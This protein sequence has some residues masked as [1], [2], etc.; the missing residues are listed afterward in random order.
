MLFRSIFKFFSGKLLI[1]ILKNPT[2]GAFINSIIITENTL[3]NIKKICEIINKLNSGELYDSDNEI[4]SNY[5]PFNW[6]FIEKSEKIYK[7][8]E[9]ATKVRLPKFIEDLID[10][11]LP[12]DFRYNYFEQNKDEVINLRSIC[13][14]INEAICLINAMD[15]CKSLIFLT[16]E[17]NK[18]KK[19][20]EKL[21][22]KNTKKIIVEIMKKENNISNETKTSTNNIN[23][24]ETKIKPKTFYFLI[25]SLI[26]NNDYQKLFDVSQPTKSFS[27]KEIKDLSNETNIINN[28]I[29]KIKNFICS[30][31]YNFDRLIETNFEP[32][33][34][35][36]TE[37]IFEELNFLMNSSYYV[38]DNSIPFDWYIKSIFEYLEKIPKTL[39]ENDCEELYKEIENDVNNS[40][41]QLDFMKLSVILEKLNYSERG[42][43]FYNNNKQILLDIRI[44][45]EVNKII[46]NEYIPVNI[47]FNWKDNNK[48]S[49]KIDISHFKEKDRDNIEKIKDYENA[50]KSILTFNIENFTKKFPDLRAY[51]VY[52]DIDIFN[53]QQDLNFPESLGKYFDIVFTHLES[54]QNWKKKFFY[55]LD[56]I[57]ENIFDYVMGKLYDKIFPIEPNKLDN[58]IFQQTVNLSKI[59]PNYL[60]GNK[61]QFVFGSFIKD[62]QK[63]YKQLEL[64]KSP[65]KKLLNL[66]SISNDIIFFY[67]FN[68]YNE[69]GL[70]DE[71]SLLTYAAIKIQPF[72]LDS[73]YIFMKLY[74]KVG[75]FVFDGN[76]L[77]KL[78]GVIDIISKIKINNFDEITEQEFLEK[79]KSIKS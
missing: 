41:S 7:I 34:I 79:L 33:T 10:D 63:N 39:T 32:D 60:L 53:M 78:E 19:T 25:T 22:S 3:N 6:Y 56:K 42:K 31:L 8:F 76:N 15:K 71:I 5:T 35:E 62:V 70:D 77:E 58:I 4:N 51:E 26:A 48:R 44:K 30:L 14:N 27:I 20:L 72:L 69:I 16:P 29:I 64:E 36:N 2:L 21:K 54:N 28:N 40:L 55:K 12:L 49:F 47:F 37:K 38:F 13:F 1:P 11:I 24:E 50:R 46:Y 23:K 18:I 65:R 61:K 66:N 68:K 45:E 59:K 17:E 52:Q 75:D 74:R 67:N 9:L 43:I 57:K 73:N